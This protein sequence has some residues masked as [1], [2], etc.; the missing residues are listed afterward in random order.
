MKKFVIFSVVFLS[1][2]LAP[3]LFTILSPVILFSKD[4]VIREFE[5]ILIQDFQRAQFQK[6]YMTIMVVFTMMV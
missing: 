1:L 4:N 3:I 5:K 2:I 6:K